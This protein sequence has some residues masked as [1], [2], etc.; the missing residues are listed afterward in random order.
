MRSLPSLD[1]RRRDISGQIERHR[2]D[3]PEIVIGVLADDVD[4]AGRAEDTQSVGRAVLFPE[5][6]DH[7][8]LRPAR[9]ASSSMTA[10]NATMNSPQ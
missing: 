2:H 9:H 10:P 5:F 7:E 3:E 6:L 4:A 1:R 8:C